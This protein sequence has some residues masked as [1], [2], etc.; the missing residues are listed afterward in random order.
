MK[1]PVLYT[2]GQ[3]TRP[4]DEFLELLNAHRT[5]VVDVTTIPRSR[6]NPPR[7]FK[8]DLLD[9]CSSVSDQSPIGRPAHV[10]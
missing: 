3:S 9:D 8:V 2:I 6:H 1:K 7:C 4:I 10:D 5:E